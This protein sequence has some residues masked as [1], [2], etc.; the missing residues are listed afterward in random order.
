VRRRSRVSSELLAL[1]HE[2]VAGR[3]ADRMDMADQEQ[4]GAVRLRRP[5]AADKA[6]VEVAALVRQVVAGTGQ[7]PT[8]ADACWVARTV[9][10]ERLGRRELVG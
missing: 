3:F 1:N 9:K 4:V 6:G 7:E 2:L 5:I 10:V 8:S